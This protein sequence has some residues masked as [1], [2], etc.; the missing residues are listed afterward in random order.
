MIWPVQRPATS[1]T[2]QRF[3]LKTPHSAL[4]LRL[5]QPT[6]CK[7]GHHQAGGCSNSRSRNR[8]VFPNLM[9]E[10]NGHGILATRYSLHA[11]ALRMPFKH[12][13]KISSFLLSGQRF[14]QISPPHF[15]LCIPEAKTAIELPV[16]PTDVAFLRLRAGECRPTRP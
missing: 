3:D 5:E 2:K 1:R 16:G 10:H 12:Y 15:R 6:Q 14:A 9:L 4:R 7:K 8:R 11:H 13:R